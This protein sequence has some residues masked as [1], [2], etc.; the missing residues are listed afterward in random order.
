MRGSQPLGSRELVYL[1]ALSLGVVAMF[2]GSVIQAIHW[3]ISTAS[4]G[5]ALP[6]ADP[7]ASLSVLGAILG[8]IFHLLRQVRN[9]YGLVV[10]LE[11]ACWATGFAPILPGFILKGRALPSIGTYPYLSLCLF[12]LAIILRSHRLGV[13]DFRHKRPTPIAP[14]STEDELTLSGKKGKASGWKLVASVVPVGLSVVLAVALP[15]SDSDDAP[16]EALDPVTTCQVWYDTRFLPVFEGPVQ[17]WIEWTF[18]LDEHLDT[19][20]LGEQVVFGIETGLF[21]PELLD[22]REMGD[23]LVMAMQN[24]VVGIEVATL[25]PYWEDGEIE[26]VISATAAEMRT[27]AKVLALDVQLAEIVGFAPFPNAQNFIFDL[28]SVALGLEKACGLET[29][30]P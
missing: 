6:A 15:V 30:S 17:Q 21:P 27:I 9:D 13:F 3:A 28:E 8:V 14:S 5:D 11:M 18:A 4:W 12:V 19:P 24:T 23:E 10:P 20:G 22:R 7:V 25:D 2:S 16:E 29:T 26:G 1:G